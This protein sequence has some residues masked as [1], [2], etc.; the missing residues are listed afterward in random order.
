[1]DFEKKF[2]CNF[3]GCS[4][5]YTTAGN[6]KTHLKSHRGEF[7]FYCDENSCHKG[8]SP[9]SYQRKTL[10]ILKA[11]LR[12]HDGNTFKCETCSKEFTTQSDLRKHHRIHS[13]E[14]PFRCSFTNCNKAFSVS[15]HLKS[16]LSTHND[17]RPFKCSEK[18]CDKKFKSNSSLNNHLRT[19]HN[20]NILK[21]KNSNDEN[22]VIYIQA[23]LQSNSASS[24]LVP[25]LNL[26][27]LNLENLEL[28]LLPQEN[29][30]A[31][32]VTFDSSK[33]IITINS[34]SPLPTQNLNQETFYNLLLKLQQ[35]NQLELNN[36]SLTSQFY[37]SQEELNR[38][39]AAPSQPALDPLVTQT[40]FELDQPF[41]NPA[42]I[43][44]NY[45]INQLEQTPSFQME[46][47]KCQELCCL[48]KF[49]A[50]DDLR[51]NF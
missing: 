34:D 12:I 11:H 15:H 49:N 31:S 20:F 38:L 47:P 9:C 23:S 4:R 33:G 18:T 16:H 28:D 37:L 45:A 43:M 21:K 2:K 25:E 42:P 29:P 10:R 1:M 50:S 24:S 13:G 36:Q 40:N 44:P 26:S 32:L 7:S 46:P 41:L 48:L 8:A 3:D 14:K 22:E 6:L 30:T 5:T 19:Q 39:I 27:D 35:N 17:T 51:L